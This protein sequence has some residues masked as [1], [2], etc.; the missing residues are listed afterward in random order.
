M[1]RGVD[2]V[3]E[4]LAIARRVRVQHHEVHHHPAPAPVMMGDQ[5][6]PQGGESV[7]RVDVR[8]QDRPLAGDPDGPEQRLGAAVCHQLSFGGT[9]RGVGV[10][11]VSGN[12]LVD[13]R[14]GWCDVELP[15]LHLG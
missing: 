11:E 2:R 4:I 7:Q 13:R 8:E 10:E 14:V 5:E 15:K 9:E 12:L 1:N 6:L 3:I